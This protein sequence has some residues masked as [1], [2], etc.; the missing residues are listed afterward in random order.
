MNLR[1]LCANHRQWLIADPARAEQYW[2]EWLETG[3]H[4]YEQGGFQEAIP[5]FGCAFE[6]AESLL[7]SAWPGINEAASR[8][9]LSSVCLAQ[10]YEWSGKMDIR[11]YLLTQASCRLAK[12]LSVAEQYT[13]I[14]HCMQS[15]YW[16]E[17]NPQL[18]DLCANI[19]LTIPV[20]K[21]AMQVH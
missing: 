7:S 2:L 17:L 10:A 12:E 4:Y 11:N 19:G 18:E 21:A 9:T 20:S 8:F 15:L 1:Y 13:H 6:L 3:N 5:Y 14:S 16:A